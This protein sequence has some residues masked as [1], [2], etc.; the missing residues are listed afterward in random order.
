MK[1][2]KTDKSIEPKIEKTVR[3]L[4]NFNTLI[5]NPNYKIKV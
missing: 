2:E 4:L 5:L 1:Q 3:F